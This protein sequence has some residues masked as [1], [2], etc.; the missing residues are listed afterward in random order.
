MGNLSLAIFLITVGL[1]VRMLFDDMLIG[2]VVYLFM[3]LLG[4]V[5]SRGL[6]VGGKP[7]PTIPVESG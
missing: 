6:H 7:R 4:V 3:L 5:F 2:N 1:M